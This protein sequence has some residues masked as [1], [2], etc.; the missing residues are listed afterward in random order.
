M[1]FIHELIYIEI[2]GNSGTAWLGLFCA[3]METKITVKG[4][5]CFTK[6]KPR[7]VK[8]RFAYHIFVSFHELCGTVFL[9]AICK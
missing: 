2:P 8:I 1:I 9:Y 6:S 7:T 4:K 3:K 5:F